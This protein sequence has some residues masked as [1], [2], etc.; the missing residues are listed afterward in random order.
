[1]SL[2]KGIKIVLP[3]VVL[4][5]AGA[6]MYDL[7]NSK[8]EPA[9]L[10]LQE[11]IWQ[12]AV[13]VA[14]KQSLSPSITLYGRVESPELLQAAAPGAGI[15]DSVAVRVG[16]TVTK[17][18][19]LVTLDRRDFDSL[20][21]QAKAELSDVESQA[22]ELQI[23]HRL[24]QDSLKT[25]QDLLKLAEEEVERMQQLKNQNLGSDSALNQARSE[26]GRQQ[27]SLRNRQLEVESFPAKLKMLEAQQTKFR[28]RLSDAQLMIER[29]QVIAPFDGIISSVPVSIGD[30]VAIGE[31]LVTLYPVDSLEIRAHIPATYI[32]SIQH[33]VNRGISLTAKLEANQQSLEFK[34]KRLA[35]EAEATGIDAYFHTG[36]LS[37]NLRPGALL[38]LNLSLPARDGVVAIPFQATYG[39]S[40]IYLMQ[41]GRLQGLDVETIGQY[42]QADG[43]ASL[44]VANPTLRNGDKI[45]VTHL[46]NAVTGLK[47]KTADHG[48]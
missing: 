15:V 25:E 2:R 47:V 29:S 4:G 44:L 27:L 21:L 17:G 41:D 39:N 20:L 48:Q 9:K 19:I 30:R 40:R 18:Q 13:M 32:S 43:S 31:T 28:A 42:Y 46:P 24:N 14:E 36:E 34:L 5:A 8:P 3:L 33:A 45:V 1:M 22:E 26:L 10:Q 11:K 7:K 12:V 35:G 23:R 6:W 16:T 38:A 37:P